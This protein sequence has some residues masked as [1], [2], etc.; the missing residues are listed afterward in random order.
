MS[1]LERMGDVVT[2][3]H[4]HDRRVVLRHRAR[5]FDVLNIVDRF[6]RVRGVL[7]DV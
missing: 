4:L 3:R 7:R 2:S 6:R 5:S 1:R